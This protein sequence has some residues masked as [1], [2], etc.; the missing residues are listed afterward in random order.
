MNSKLVIQTLKKKVLM[1]EVKSERLVV[2]HAKTGMRLFWKANGNGLYTSSLFAIIFPSEERFCS[3]FWFSDEY[4]VTNFLCVCHAC[5][6]GA[7]LVQR[8]YS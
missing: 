7:F 2:F 4:V 1:W 6:C 5:L 8:M 3:Y